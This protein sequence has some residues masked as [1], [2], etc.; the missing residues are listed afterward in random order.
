MDINRKL[1]IVDGDAQSR[2]LKT[3]LLESAGLRL[4]AVETGRDALR[5]LDAEVFD[6]IVVNDE[7]ADGDEATFYQSIKEKSPSTAVLRMAHAQTAKS[8]AAIDAAI[9]GFLLDP[10][11]PSELIT[12]VRSLLRLN[13]TRLALRDAEARLQL[14]QDAGG[15]AVVDCDLVTRRALWSDKFAQI[16]ALPPD[17]TEK[18]LRFGMILNVVHPDDR[19]ALTKEYRRLVREGGQFER[20][21]R[22]RQPDDGATRWISARGSFFRGDGQI[23]RILCLCSDITGRKRSELRNA[24]LAAVV[25]SSIDAI[26]SVDFDDLIRTW[27]YGAEQL[28]GYS[29][30]DVIGKPA[31]FIVP[32]ELLDERRG[33][34]AQLM[35]G[36]AV[37]YQ[38]RRLDRDGH[39]MDV[40]IRGAPVRSVEGN[41]FGASL[42][43]RDITA[44]KQRE[45]HVRFLMRELTHRSKNLLAVIQ[46]M[47]RQSLSLQADPKDFVDRFSERLSSLAGSHDLL[48]NDDWAGASLNQLIR[49]QLQHFGDLLDTRILID[50][51]DIILQP[52]A[53]QN[54]GIVLHELST[55]AAKF[56]A[57]SVETGVVKV[58]WTIATD[59]AEPRM[60]LK[61]REESGPLVQ[62]PER[63]GFGRVVMERIAG[64]ALGG[65]S[66]ATFA[67][68][69]VVWELDVPTKSVVREKKPEPA[70][71]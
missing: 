33:M 30:K 29:A 9:D 47:A 19:V 21:F 31:P 56:G 35:K 44:Q 62:T 11:E 36:E 49:S 64:Q 70:L 6:L 14:V 10:F 2:N 51:K 23:Q 48:S 4:T 18:R 57:L 32:P 34:M 38:T 8:S 24:Q 67:P 17:T 61:W 13:R 12:L 50:G 3:Q 5:S 22:V 20:E 26:V 65:Q 63:R 71:S 28:F 15:L 27:N 16:F 55:N 46:A 66:K 60:R 40:W 25:A 53:A 7:A 42:I 52:E 39:S 69:G 68:D 43:I 37:E 41:L 58:S 54:I 59:G 45:A 1:L